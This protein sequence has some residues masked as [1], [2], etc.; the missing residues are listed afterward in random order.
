LRHSALALPLVVQWRP[1]DT[2]FAQLEGRL[3]HHRRW[4]EKEIESQNQDFVD[5]E[6][7]R[8]RYVRFLY[9]QAEGN[10]NGEL[11]EQRIAKRMRRVEIVGRWLSNSPQAQWSSVGKHRT[12]HIGSCNWFLDITKYRNW[13]KKSF[14][15]DQANDAVA[16]QSDWH[17][18][19][20]FVQGI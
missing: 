8:K 18:R 2:R 12:E 11:E 15:R 19:V 3:T 10:S 9:R 5:V 14:N 6:Q 13:K 16:L 4:L 7:H 1:I 20:L 17:D